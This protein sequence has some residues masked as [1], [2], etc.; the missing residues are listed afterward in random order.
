MKAH[1]MKNELEKVAKIVPE[2]RRELDQTYSEDTGRKTKL[3]LLWKQYESKHRELRDDRQ[4][5]YLNLQS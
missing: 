4:Y 2:L 3:K 1:E 5:G